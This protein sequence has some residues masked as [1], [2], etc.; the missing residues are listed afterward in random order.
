ML[1]N[2]LIETV[3]LLQI[4]DQPMLMH[5]HIECNCCTAVNIIGSEGGV[6]L[7]FKGIII[8]SY[9]SGLG[10]EVTAHLLMSG[11]CDLHFIEEEAFPF[12]GITQ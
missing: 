10:S 11:G 3:E 8:L 9:S 5:I 12:V 6:L 2:E 4:I 7:I 1:F